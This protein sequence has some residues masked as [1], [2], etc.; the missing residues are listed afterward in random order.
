MV[1][2]LG[3]EDLKEYVTGSWGEVLFK[4]WVIQSRGSFGPNTPWGPQTASVL[5]FGWGPEKR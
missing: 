2:A 3:N 4:F 1:E 5:F